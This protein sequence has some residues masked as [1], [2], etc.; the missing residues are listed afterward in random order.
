MEISVV[1]RFRR[2]GF[3]CVTILLTCAF[4][5]I[6]LLTFNSTIITALQPS[7]IAGLTLHINESL[8]RS[9]VRN[10][11]VTSA[12]EIYKF[13]INALANHITHIPTNLLCIDCLI[14]SVFCLRFARFLDLLFGSFVYDCAYPYT[15]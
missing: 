3:S 5:Q 2:V 15:K 1:T 14:S 7:F 13:K 4:L 12:Y 10:F 11:V 9:I 6:C 8:K